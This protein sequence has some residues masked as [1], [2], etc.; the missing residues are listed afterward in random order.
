MPA[1]APPEGATPAH[2]KPSRPH[3]QAQ[4]SRVVYVSEPARLVPPCLRFRLRIVISVFT[5]KNHSNYTSEKRCE[6]TRRRHWRVGGT[7][8]FPSFGERLAR[9]SMDITLT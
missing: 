4:P 8:I 3:R 5:S 6:P 9:R 1:R 2:P 7:G